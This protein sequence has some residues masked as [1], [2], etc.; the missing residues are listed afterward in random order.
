MPPAHAIASRMSESKPPH[1]PS[2]RTGKIH[3]FHVEPVIP[4]ELFASAAMIPAT[5]VPCHELLE[6]EQPENCP[7]FDSCC[8]TQSPA[9]D[10]SESRPPPSFAAAAFT[11]KS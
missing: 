4:S 7:W 1:L 9:S 3:E 8:V 2:A 6:T 5:R 10:A 11:I